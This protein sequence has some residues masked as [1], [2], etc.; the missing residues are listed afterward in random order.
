MLKSDIIRIRHMLDS[1]LEAEGFINNKHRSDIGNDRKLEL[2][3]VKC[4]EIIG[5]A[6]NSISKECKDN[7]PQIQWANII[8]M[9]NRLIHSY[10][11]INLDILWKTL[12]DDLP[13]LIIELRKIISSA[14]LF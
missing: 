8:G 4:I 10:F 6:A 12:V 1:A 3:L 13:P 7:I 5:E 2:A 11:E 14:T 9:R